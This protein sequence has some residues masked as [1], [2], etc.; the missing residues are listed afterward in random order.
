MCFSATASFVAS[1][2]LA[3][4]SVASFKA[5]DKKHKLLAIVPFLFAIQ[6]A[7]E[8]IQWLLPHPG[9]IC[10]GVGYAYLFFAYL[11]WPIYIP[12]VLSIIDNH[13]TKLMRW[14]MYLGIVL[15]AYLL[16]VMMFVPIDVQII[17]RS[18]GYYVNVPMQYIAIATY[19]FVLFG[20]LLSS[21]KK[22]IRWFGVASFALALFSGIIFF[23]TFTSTWCFFGAI[24]SSL[25]YFYIRQQSKVANPRS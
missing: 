5:A 18:I 17:H 22:L 4:I 3:V 19:A 14:Y 20:S 6:Q 11:F 16:S 24:L 7:I 8:G 2:S 1:G 15:S 9:D 25:V 21:S 13:R 23:N 10:V 12:F